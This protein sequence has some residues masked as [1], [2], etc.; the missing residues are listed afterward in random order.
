[1][2]QSQVTQAVYES[3]NNAMNPDDLTN[4]QVH[5]NLSVNS[6]AKDVGG[7]ISTQACNTS[8]YA[9]GCFESILDT[10][11]IMGMAQNIPTTYW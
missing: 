5:F 2:T 8:V 9:G 6:I 10:Q 7:H 1:M 3:G 4:F 11:Y